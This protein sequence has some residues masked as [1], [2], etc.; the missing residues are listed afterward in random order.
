MHIESQWKDF[1]AV[2]VV[3]DTNQAN[4]VKQVLRW[5]KRNC[6]KNAER[7]VPVIILCN[8]VDDPSYQQHIEQVRDIEKKVAEEFELNVKACV[9]NLEESEPQFPKVIAA[10]A[11]NALLYQSAQ[12]MTLEMFNAMMPMEKIE[13]RCKLEVGAFE[14]EEASDDKKYSMA[15]EKLRDPALYK[16]DTVKRTLISL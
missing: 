16:K 9:Q 15:Y 7:D 13:R 3:V 5:V 10:S 4:H 8:K 2:V 6:D 14:W 11:Q 12:I 1:D